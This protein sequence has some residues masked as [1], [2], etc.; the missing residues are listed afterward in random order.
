MTTTVQEKTP[1]TMVPSTKAPVKAPTTKAPTTKAYRPRGDRHE[2]SDSGGHADQAELH[3]IDPSWSEVALTGRPLS[4]HYQVGDA[5]RSVD[6]SYDAPAGGELVNWSSDAP[7]SAVI[8]RSG[9][10]CYA[11]YEY[12]PPATNA[13]GLQPPLVDRDENL[14]AVIACYQPDPIDVG[15]DIHLSDS[16]DPVEVGTQ[17]AYVIEVDASGY[18]NGSSILLELA[19]EVTAIDGGDCTI[20]AQQIQC[21]PPLNETVSWTTAITVEAVQSGVAVTWAHLQAEGD[22]TPVSA[23]ALE[24]TRIVGDRGHGGGCGGHEDGGDDHTSGGDHEDG[25]CG[26]DQHGM[27][28]ACTA[29]D[30]A[31]QTL[32]LQGPFASRRYQLDGPGQV[33]I[34]IEI[35]ETTERDGNV[36]GKRARR[37]RAGADGQTDRG[38]PE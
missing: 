23:S 16:T 20:S 33:E 30:P 22:E 24:V 21:A 25:A 31:A 29:V 19:P 9:Q 18:L 4:G 14:A 1:P 26:S 36:G 13:S 7:L 34:Q 27:A 35:G 10:G 37:R 11:T 12:E 17:F 32:V 38:L 3:D 2:G 8:L 6:S 15:I 5:H 28:A